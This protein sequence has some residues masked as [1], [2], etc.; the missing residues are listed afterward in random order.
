MIPINGN[1]FTD[2]LTG[3]LEENVSYDAPALILT[4]L[5]VDT[6]SG[7]LN[8]TNEVISDTD[9]GTVRPE[10]SISTHTTAPEVTNLPVDLKSV[11]PITTIAKHAAI[12]SL[13]DRTGTSAV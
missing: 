5:P 2:Q 11:S 12:S 10:E 1:I 6:R 13:Y 7:Y 4:N 3:R 9:H 8:S